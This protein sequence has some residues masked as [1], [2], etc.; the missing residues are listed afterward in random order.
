MSQRFLAI[1]L[2]LALSASHAEAIVVSRITEFEAGTPVVA[3]DLNA[4]LDNILDAINGNIN[5]DNIVNGAIATADLATASVTTAKINDGAVTR[6]KQEA[7][8]QQ[9]S[10]SSGNFQTNGEVEAAVTNLSATI[11]TT[12]RPVWVGLQ[13]AGGLTAPG[14]LHYRNNGSGATGNSAIVSVRRAGATVNQ[15]YVNSRNISSS[16]SDISIAVPCSSFSFLD[17]PASGSNSYVVY[18]RAAT[19]DDGILTVENCKLVVF[20]L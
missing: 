17:T 18:G 2:L 3:D 20:E 16:T 5:S 11:I 6:A 9:I 10:S 15:A 4:E 7:V 8:G 12:G 19:S 1:S 13:S 14:Q